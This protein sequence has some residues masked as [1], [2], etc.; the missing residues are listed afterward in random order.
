MDVFLDMEK[1]IHFYV[2]VL[3]IKI[4]IRGAIQRFLIEFNQMAS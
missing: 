3:H 2:M 1:K 4:E